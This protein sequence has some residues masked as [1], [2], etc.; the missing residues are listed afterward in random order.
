MSLFALL[1]ERRVKL[2]VRLLRRRVGSFIFDLLDQRRGPGSVFEYKVSLLN[3]SH[4]G[5]VGIDA[6]IPVEEAFQINGLANL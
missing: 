2:C 6:L 3:H 1:R 5:D 4:R